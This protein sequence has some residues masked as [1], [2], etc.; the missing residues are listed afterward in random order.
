MENKR[1]VTFTV[2]RL[3]NMMRRMTEGCLGQ[4]AALTPMQGRIIGLITHSPHENVYQR[5]VERAF[6]I[7]RST[8]SAILQGMEKNGLI[9]RES[10]PQ[11][12]RLKKLVLTERAVAFTDRFMREMARVEAVITQGVT[13]EEMDMFFGVVAKFE[14]NLTKNTAT[15]GEPTRCGCHREEQE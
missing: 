1:E 3:L 14:N 8:A 4:D 6:Q 2:R 10:V 11:D 12:A 9:C 15:L 13:Q 5:D 7:R